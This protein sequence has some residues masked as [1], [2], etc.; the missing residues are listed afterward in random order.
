LDHLDY[1]VVLAEITLTSDG[2]VAYRQL[3][4][5]VLKQYV[6]S[7]W[8]DEDNADSMPNE[9][10]KV[11]IRELLLKGLGDPVSK[12]RA[13]VVWPISMMTGVLSL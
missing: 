8:I 2:P 13:A 3:A 1:G 6:K 12:I 7:H 11:T 10:T 4:S 9:E 5:L